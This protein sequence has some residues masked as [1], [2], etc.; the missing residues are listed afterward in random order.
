[1]YSKKK[2]IPKSH[3]HLIKRDKNDFIVQ[4]FRSSG[5]GGQNVNKRD[6]AVRIIDKKTGLR[7]EC[8]EYRTQLQNK[9]EAFIKLSNMIIDDVL[10]QYKNSLKRELNTEEVRVYKKKQDLVKDSRTGKEYSY[11]NVVEKC[12]LDDL[13]EDLKNN[14]IEVENE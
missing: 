3:S 11:K 13:I 14:E 4:T 12:N 7:A 8:Q 9:R 5:N 10:E 6:T 2:Q 1:M